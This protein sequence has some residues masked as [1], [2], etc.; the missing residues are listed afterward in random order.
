MKVQGLEVSHQTEITVLGDGGARL[1]SLNIDGDGPRSCGGQLIMVLGT[2]E[3]VE[4]SDPLRLFR[5]V[6]EAGAASVAS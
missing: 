2:G 1:F 5:A 3:R 6:F 4:L